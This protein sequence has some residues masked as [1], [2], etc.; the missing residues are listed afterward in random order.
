M[1]HDTKRYQVRSFE[2]GTKLGF[3]QAQDLVLRP[4]SKLGVFFMNTLV[5]VT[6]SI[7]AILLSIG[8]ENH[9]AARCNESSRFELFYELS[10]INRARPVVRKLWVAVVYK[11]GCE[12]PPIS[13]LFQ[14]GQLWLKS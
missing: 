12:D 14:S 5:F 4:G 13:K 10:S 6:I 7:L 11:M 9:V 8:L 3:N 2:P 1:D